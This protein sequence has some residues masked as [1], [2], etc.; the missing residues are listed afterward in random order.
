MPRRKP[1]DE[2]TLVSL[3]QQL[4]NKRAVARAMGISEVT[5]YQLL[6]RHRGICRRCTNAVDAGHAFCPTCRQAIRDNM[7]RRRTK[8]R[9]LGVCMECDD[10]VVPPSTTY[11]AVHRHA[12]MRHQ[13]NWLKAQVP[14]P[15]GP[16]AVGR[17]ESSIRRTFGAA[18]IAVWR[19]FGGCC[20]LCDISHTERRVGLHHIDRQSGP[21]TEENLICLCTKCHSVVHDL[22]DH[23]DPQ[24][25]LSWVQVNYWASR[26]PS[27]PASVAR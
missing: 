27:H 18:G 8:R 13:A 22:A 7:K 17:R 16:S 10:P 26:R 9:R 20:Q 12:H 6:K 3:F 23:P 14:G 11:C 15:R 19:A 1:V 21:T 4:Q 2:Q 25:L 24:R 5:V